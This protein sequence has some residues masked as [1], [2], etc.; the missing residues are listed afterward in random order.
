VYGGTGALLRDDLPR[1]GVNVVRFDALD[2]RA[3]DAA[4]AQR[5]KLVLVESPTNPLCRTVD[6]TGLAQRARSAG[7]LTMVDATFAPPPLQRPIEAGIDLVMHSA[8]KFFSGHHDCLGGVVSGRHELLGPIE[9]FRRRTGAI[10]APDTAWLLERSMRTLELRVRQGAETAARLAEFL[11]GRVRKVH[12]AGMGALLAFEVDD[13]AAVYN[14]F[15]TVARAV[16]LGGVE[17]TALIPAHASHV[18]IAPEERARLGIADDLI[19]VSVGLEPFETLAN[20]LEQ[21]IG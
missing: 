16:S 2:E 11:A 3:W 10:L 20:D 17:S 13:A 8:T 18:M 7:A 9:A 19:R 6:L 1:F 21:A 4:L 14:R 5:P 12:Y 15:E